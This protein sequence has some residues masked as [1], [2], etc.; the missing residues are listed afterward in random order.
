MSQ[1]NSEIAFC[2]KHRAKET[3]TYALYVEPREILT[4]WGKKKPR[5]KLIWKID[6]THTKIPYEKVTGKTGKI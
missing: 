5:M 6:K 4:F 2:A 1:N 3:K